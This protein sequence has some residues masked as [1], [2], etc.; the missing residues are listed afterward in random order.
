MAKKVATLGMEGFLEDINLKIDYLM[1][2][3]FYTKFKQTTLYR[4][5]LVSLSKTLQMNGHDAIDAKN[6]IQA[7][8]QGF[9]EKFF[10]TTQ[11]EVLNLT[12]DSDPGIN[13]Q[14]DAIVSE[15]GSVEGNSVS[16][17]YSV[18]SKN[19]ML[20]QLVNR[21]NGTTIYSA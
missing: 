21:S 2:C 14:I 11:V 16:V 7:D 3:Y 8:L 6:A 18:F 12:K 17:G 5:R 13:L 9:L 10:T 20:K 4:G 1:C 15:Q 19:S